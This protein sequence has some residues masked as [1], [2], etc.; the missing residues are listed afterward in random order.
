MV[1]ERGRSWT[2]VGSRTYDARGTLLSENRIG[3]ET[4]TSV[5]SDTVPGTDDEKTDAEP[6]AEA[7]E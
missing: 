1:L 5:M 6:D 7:Q 4:R 3:E 2:R